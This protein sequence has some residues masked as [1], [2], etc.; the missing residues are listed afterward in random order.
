MA[1]ADNIIPA[2]LDG[3]ADALIHS[4]PV[5]GPIIVCLALYAWWVTKVLIDGKAAHIADLK[6]ALATV[7]ELKDVL[8]TIPRRGQR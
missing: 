8:S 2:P 1:G 3:S 6:V 7:H 4:A 5:Y